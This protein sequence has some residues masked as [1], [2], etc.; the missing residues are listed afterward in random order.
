VPF[1]APARH[2]PADA[3]GEFSA[4]LQPPLSAV[5]LLRSSTIGDR[6]TASRQHLLDHAQAQR[7][8]KIEPD[9]VADELGGVA[10]AGIDWVSRVDIRNKYPSIPPLANPKPLNL[11]VPLHMRI[12]FRQ[13]TKIAR[14]AISDSDAK[15]AA[16]TLMRH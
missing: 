15:R 14:L 5:D 9:R 4:E 2:S 3:I 13:M 16:G 8:P 6:N 10:I 11:T 12:H 1:V 7:E